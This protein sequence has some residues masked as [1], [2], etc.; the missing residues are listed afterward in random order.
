MLSYAAT[1]ASAP[2]VKTSAAHHMGRME[3]GSPIQF[4]IAF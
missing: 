2:L 1:P 4:F 3:P